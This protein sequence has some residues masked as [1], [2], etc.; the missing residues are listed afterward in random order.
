MRFSN[1]HRAKSN[2]GW[3]LLFLLCSQ[4]LL[5]LE[6]DKDQPINIE[7]DSVE[8]D[9]A[10]KRSIYKGNVILTQ[11]SIRITADSVAITQKNGTADHVLATGNP[12]TFRQKGEKAAENINA[13]A[14]KAEYQAK[15]DTLILQGSAEL[16][17]G[18][19]V[20]KSDRIVYD[21][22]KS[23]VKAG[24]SAKGT[25]RVRATIHQ[26]KDDDK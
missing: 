11:G 6:S 5:A 4:P 20:F 2:W 17:Q 10:K 14:K 3:A 8:I 1:S 9:D 21:R 12:V 25:G 18:K 13:E 22:T 16:I 23:V 7:A 19:D 24:T 15:D 26:S